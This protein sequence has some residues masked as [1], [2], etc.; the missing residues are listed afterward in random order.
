MVRLVPERARKLRAPGS[1]SLRFPC[2]DKVERHAVEIALGDSERRKR[3]ICRM[4]ASERLEARIVESLHTERD[5]I[6]ARGTVAREPFRFDAG[7][8]GFKRNLNIRIDFPMAGN[9]IEDRCHRARLHQGWGAAAEEDAGDCASGRAFREMR[10]LGEI[11]GAVTLLVHPAVA[12][13]RVEVAIGTLGEAERPMH[14]DAERLHCR[15]RS[16][17]RMLL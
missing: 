13:M 4:H 10:K 6:D 2:I 8:I 15:V 1:Q 12:Y 14:I 11:G 5:A 17:P 16:H 9:R 3:F 7:W